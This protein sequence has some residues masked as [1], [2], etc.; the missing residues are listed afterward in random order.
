[1]MGQLNFP[2][3]WPYWP[4]L[5]SGLWVTIQL[6]VMATVGGVALGIFG[7]AL[8]SGKPTVLSRIWGV[9]VELIRNTPFVVQL[10]F[11]VF[12][13]PNLGL[14]L[15]AGEAALLA[16]LINLGAYS[17]EII[18]A[19]IQVTPK[20]QWEAGRVLGLSRTQTFIRIVLPPS[21]KRIYPALVSQCIIV[22]L[23]SSVVSQVSYEELTFA[24]NLIQSRTFLSFEV[25]LV[26]TLMYLALS[27]AMRQLLLAAGRKWFGEQP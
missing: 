21:L 14:K 9:Y 1:M 7:A 27:I 12:G 5:I 20:G 19:G 26:T 18:R 15:T 3:L 24:A 25:Y 11:I 23:G 13:L 6:T 22:M 4:E 2:A 17:T 8:R 10:F 16:M